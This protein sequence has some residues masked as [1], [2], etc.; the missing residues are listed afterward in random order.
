[1]ALL[2]PPFPPKGKAKVKSASVTGEGLLVMPANNAWRSLL[3][4]ARSAFF[5]AQFCA[6][7]ILLTIMIVDVPTHC[8]SLSFLEDVGLNH[9]LL[10]K[11]DLNMTEIVTYN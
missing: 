9:N 4:V 11:L 10:Q 7:K 3:E 8:S 6:K 1:M 5:G 2:F